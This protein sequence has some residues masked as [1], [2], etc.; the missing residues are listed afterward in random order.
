MKI[1]IAKLDDYRIQIKELLGSKFIKEIEKNY[2]NELM[3]AEHI[4]KRNIDH[5]FSEWWKSFNQD[6]EHSKMIGSFQLSEFSL[7]TLNLLND[8]SSIKNIPN[9]ERILYDIR[10][11]SKFYSACFE[12]SIIAS[13]LHKGYEVVILEEKSD[14]GIRTCDFLIKNNNGEVSV[15]CKSLDDISLNERFHWD[16]LKYKLAR[17]L[18]ENKRSWKIEIYANKQIKGNEKEFL[19][20]EILRD[21]KNNDL[22]RKEF[23]KNDFVVEYTKITEW[24]KEFSI[25]LTINTNSE[26][27]YFDCELYKELDVVKNIRIVEVW[28]Y[29]EYEISKRLISNFKTAVGQIPKAGPGIV[30]IGVPYKLGSHLLHIIDNSYDSIY[31]KL[32]RDSN[33]VNAVVI[34][35][36]IVENNPEMPL[37]PQYYVV[38]NIETYSPLPSEFSIVGTNEFFKPD[39]IFDGG[40]GT[41]EFLFKI[42]KKIQNHMHFPIFDY[43]SNDGKYQFRVWLTW[44]KRFRMDLVNPLLG[45]VFVETD[46]FNSN[47]YK[48]Y[49]FAGRW[50]KKT[51]S[52]FI[53]GDKLYK[54]KLSGNIIR[55]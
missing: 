32:N 35:G 30:H 24:N 41:I 26:N 52:I 53:D 29:E 31:R 39:G 50:C 36:I 27:G 11:K 18:Y 49:A 40:E 2:C 54:K 42:P 8:L 10:N 6:V 43:S 51:I 7:R 45:R 5:P 19:F 1:E 3:L 13:Y 17:K 47:P 16:D 37:I 46:E 33:R 25:P 48:D 15:E 14:E 28:P 21:I 22:K 34:S 23:L 44:T 4:I 12:A 38:P 20:R 55:N 9:T